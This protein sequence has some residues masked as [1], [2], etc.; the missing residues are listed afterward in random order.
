MSIEYSACFQAR[1]LIF[2]FFNFLSLIFSLT[3]QGSAQRLGG[4]S[5]GVNTGVGIGPGVGL[6]PGVGLGTGVGIGTGVGG[7]G[8]GGCATG[9]NRPISAIP[10]R[11]PGS[12]IQPVSQVGVNVRRT[13][14]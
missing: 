3:I 12:V 13:I 10:L 5:V 8:A 14:V 9:I 4:T 6:R 11:Q 7:I 1:C 2:F